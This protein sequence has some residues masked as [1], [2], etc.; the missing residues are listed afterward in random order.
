LSK[1]VRIVRNL[2][3]SFEH[4][5]LSSTLVICSALSITGCAHD[6]FVKDE[7]TAS[8]AKNDKN[9]PSIDIKNS[10]WIGKSVNELT[11]KLGA[12]V[13]TLGATLTGGPISTAYLYPSKRSDG[14]TDAYV[15]NE[16]TG[17]VIKYFCR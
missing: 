4:K 15:V 6:D 16:K 17:Q 11:N 2:K 1:A 8:V 12:P 7:P 5:L 9:S 10:P 14:C 13:Q 3:H